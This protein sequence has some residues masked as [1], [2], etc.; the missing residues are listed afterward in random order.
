MQE[1]TLPTRQDVT[2]GAIVVTNYT[3]DFDACS[4]ERFIYLTGKHSQYP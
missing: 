1:R 3:F 4:T 2:T